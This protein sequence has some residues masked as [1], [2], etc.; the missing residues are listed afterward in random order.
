MTSSG[1]WAPTYIR[2]K[3]TIPP[4]ASAAITHRTERWADTTMVSAAA[5]AA[6][7]EG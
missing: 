7:P 1:R 6:C 2:P 4:S 3:S 5:T